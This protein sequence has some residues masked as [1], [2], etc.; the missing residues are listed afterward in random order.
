MASPPE[1]QA[2]RTP[3]FPRWHS[4][5]SLP[6]SIPLRFRAFET[7]SFRPWSCRHPPP[8]AL[9]PPPRRTRLGN[10]CPPSYH[11]GDKFDGQSEHPPRRSV[12]VHHLC[13]AVR[14]PRASHHPLHGQNPITRSQIPDAESHFGGPR[15]KFS[16]GCRLPWG[17]A[18]SNPLT[19]GAYDVHF[20]TGATKPGPLPA[21]HEAGQRRCVP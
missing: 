7:C 5:S 3:H 19:D 11:Q 20:Y 6:S 16:A 9:D 18:H 21:S 10:G 2:L 15:R 13:G 4:R 12:K 1:Q 17:S 14:K 8:P